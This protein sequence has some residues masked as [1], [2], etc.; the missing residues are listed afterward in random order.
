MAKSS[1]TKGDHAIAKSFR[2]ADVHP[3]NLNSSIV[4]SMTETT[5]VKAELESKPSAPRVKDESVG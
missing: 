4:A 1:S 5:E 2:V 3:S